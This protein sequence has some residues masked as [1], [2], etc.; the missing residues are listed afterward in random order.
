MSILE[1]LSLARRDLLKPTNMIFPFPG[2]VTTSSSEALPYRLVVASVRIRV[3]STI[4]SIR[5]SPA[6]V[7]TL[8]PAMKQ[9][10]PG[11]DFWW[12]T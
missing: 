12:S 10:P 7:A 9:F 8:V 3:P 2:G 6:S 4:S 5:I 1:R 11:E